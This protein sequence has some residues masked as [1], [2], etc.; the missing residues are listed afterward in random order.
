V[1][2]IHRGAF[3]GLPGRILFMIAA[4]LMPFF[5]VTGFILYFSRR[6][7]RA[8]SKPSRSHRRATGLV[9]GE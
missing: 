9:P 3:L 4:A 6:K 5:T 7:L 8:T 1:L 2:Y